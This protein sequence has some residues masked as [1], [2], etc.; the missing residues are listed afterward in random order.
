[1][2]YTYEIKENEKEKCSRVLV[3]F[4]SL[5]WSKFVDKFAGNHQGSWLFLQTQMV[6]HYLWYLQLYMIRWSVMDGLHRNNVAEK[7][8]W[9]EMVTSPGHER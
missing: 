4:P 6:R 8:N 2:Y 7:S 3:R 5:S 9:H 1:M